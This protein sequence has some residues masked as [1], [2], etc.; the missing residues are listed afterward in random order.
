MSGNVPHLQE[1]RPFR[2]NGAIRELFEGRSNAVG[3]V[4]LRANEVT[5]VVTAPNCGND[6]KIFMTPRTGNAA[7]WNDEWWIAS[8]APGTF[9][10][11]H[12]TSANT[13]L[14]YYWLAIG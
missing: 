13:D 5:T 14:N 6:S 10:V 3:E 1:N 2:V 4:T 12:N 8:V 11:G 9:T 7:Q